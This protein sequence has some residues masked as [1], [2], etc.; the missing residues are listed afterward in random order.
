MD[1]Q[2]KHL[3]PVIAA[4]VVALAGACT[5]FADTTRPMRAALPG[6]ATVTAPPAMPGGAWMTRAAAD[7]R[8]AATQPAAAALPSP[9]QLPGGAALPKGSSIRLA[10][11]ADARSLRHLRAAAAGDPAGASISVSMCGAKQIARK[12]CGAGAQSR[13]AAASSPATAEYQAT[14]LYLCI[15]VGYVVDS[16][17]TIIGEIWDCYPIPPSGCGCP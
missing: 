9:R 14:T 15:L 1:T 11:T 16:D 5:A 17:G 7:R 2:G 12:A 3:T 6:A 10:P 8:P 13:S 4:L